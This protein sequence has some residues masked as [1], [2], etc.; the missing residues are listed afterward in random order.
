MR[1]LSLALLAC[2]CTCASPASA[3]ATVVAPT[4][5]PTPTLPPASRTVSA[6]PTDGALARAAYLAAVHA[7][8]VRNADA[9]FAAFEPTLHCFY[10]NVDVPIERVRRERWH[11]DDT[12]GL[13]L[14]VELDVLAQTPEE[15]VLRDRGF[16][17]DGRGG[18]AFLHQVMHQKVV[19]MHRTDGLWRI[20]AETSSSHVAC[21]GDRI[22]MSL[23]S[24]EAFD[25]CRSAHDTCL[26]GC[27]ASLA[28]GECS[29][30]EGSCQSCGD[31]CQDTALRCLGA[32]VPQRVIDASADAA[33]VRTEADVRR[34]ATLSLHDGSAE[35]D[36]ADASWLV[37]A[38]T[39]LGAPMFRLTG[40]DGDMPCAGS[41]AR[42]IDAWGSDDD[43]RT[44]TDVHCA[45]DDTGALARCVVS[46]D[47]ADAQ[48]IDLTLAFDGPRLRAVHRDAPRPRGPAPDGLLDRYA[49]T[50]PPEWDAT[51]PEALI[52]LSEDRVGDDFFEVTDGEDSEL[53]TITVRRLCGAH[54]RAAVHALGEAWSCGDEDCEPEWGC[55][56]YC[57]TIRFDAEHRILAHTAGMLGD[58]D[59]DPALAP[60]AR[61]EIACGHSGA[62]RVRDDE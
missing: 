21:L 11:D 29:M 5:S 39:A 13:L 53:E 33:S 28:A 7:Y 56:N 58:S 25:A 18:D 23:G 52:A 22:P 8:D 1:A 51:C 35:T 30:D 20:A 42:P 50:H 31:E 15:V 46:V 38:R 60:R 41:L 9:Y 2:G 14:A 49:L 16:F 37:S 3:P 19:V 61:R 24:S 10:G 27:A 4:I 45:V 57:E 55:G 44:V 32:H 6:P 54:A 12:H 26:H 62:L 47:V 36:P 48:A 59:F 34:F 43:E 40:M 17:R